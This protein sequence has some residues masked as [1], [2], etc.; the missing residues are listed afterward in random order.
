[1]L[2]RGLQMPGSSKAHRFCLHSTRGEKGRDE[3][4]LQE[5]GTS[6]LDGCFSSQGF[7]SKTIKVDSEYLQ[8]MVLTAENG[9]CNPC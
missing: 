8:K 2:I 9:T 5:S 7:V 1:M 4:H 3:T 6:L